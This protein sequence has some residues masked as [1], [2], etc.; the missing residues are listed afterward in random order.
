MK[1]LLHVV[2]V[3]HLLSWAVALGGVVVSMRP[4]RM[5]PGAVH[6]VLSAIVTGALLVL[7]ASLGLDR[8]IDN[9]KIGLKL[10]AAL[11]AVFLLMLGSRRAEQVT[12][13]LLGGV[14]GLIGLNVALAVL[15]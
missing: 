8:E 7:I 11:A 3:L 10:V 15:L 9:L 4:P 12:T 1:T 13:A 2:L 6:A 14:A 5:P